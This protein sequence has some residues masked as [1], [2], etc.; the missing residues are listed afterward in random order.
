MNQ[1]RSPA[2]N[3]GVKKDNMEFERVGHNIDQQI[4][5]LHKLERQGQDENIIMRQ[6]AEKSSRDSSSMRILTIIT[7]IYL[8]C[9]IVSN[10]FSTQFVNSK[11]LDTGDT[12]LEYATNAWLFFAISVPLTF[13]T[14]LIWYFWVNSEK[15]LE[16]LS[17][18]DMFYRKKRD[19]NTHLFDSDEVLP[20]LPR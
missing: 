17:K 20:D 5:A 2:R 16:L 10:F 8:P 18:N 9:T 15:L 3:S 4:A 1:I 13:F 6:L 19:R 11:E 12:K 14:I 7:M